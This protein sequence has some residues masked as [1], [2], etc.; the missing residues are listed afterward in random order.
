M[1]TISGNM[2]FASSKE[3]L[4]KNYFGIILLGMS[5][6]LQLA[7]DRI[8]SLFPKPFYKHFIMLTLTI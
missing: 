7:L 2:V 8:P 3:F 5:L 4:K 1:E 6:H